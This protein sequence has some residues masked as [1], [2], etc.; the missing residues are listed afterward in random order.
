MGSLFIYVHFDLSMRK[1][2]INWERFRL[3]VPFKSKLTIC[4]ESWFLTWFTILDSCTNGESRASY[5]ESSRG[6]SLSGQKTKDAPTQRPTAVT[7]HGMVIHV[8]TQATVFSKLEHYYLRYKVNVFQEQEHLY[9]GSF[10]QVKFQMPALNANK[11]GTCILVC[12]QQHF[13][14]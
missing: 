12:K 1:G 2:H 4:C 10:P 5:R 7:Q 3:A 6:P 14:L 11:Q 9:Q 8:F 13:I